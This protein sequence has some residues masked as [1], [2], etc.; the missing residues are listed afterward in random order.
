MSIALASFSHEHLEP[1]ANLLADRH[2]SDRSTA[3]ELPARYEDA[4]AAATVLQELM[5]DDDMTGVAAFRGGRLAGYLLG[6]PVLG[7]PTDSWAGF[8]QPR[9]AVMSLAGWATEPAD[10]QNLS[11][12][13]YAALAERWVANGIAA[14][15][16]TL[17]AHADSVEPWLDLGER[18]QSV[19][20]RAFLGNK[21]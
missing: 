18:S 1:A 12:V 3:P 6:A 2:R 7:S 10:S 20:G 21:V 19:S 14:H 15:Y 5:A 16:I 9:S 8:L 17:P 4:T 11:R 13:M